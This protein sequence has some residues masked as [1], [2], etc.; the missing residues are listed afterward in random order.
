M[1]PFFVGLVACICVNC[2]FSKILLTGV[3]SQFVLIAEL[4]ISMHVFVYVTKFGCG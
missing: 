3:L 1:S 2:I 4:Y